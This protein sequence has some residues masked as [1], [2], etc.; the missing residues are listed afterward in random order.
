[1]FRLPSSA[2]LVEPDRSSVAISSRL[3][4][5]SAN[6]TELKP[7]LSTASLGYASLSVAELASTNH[8]RSRNSGFFNGI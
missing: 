6:L 7:K 8:A 5:P 4:L 2:G 3:A 1:M